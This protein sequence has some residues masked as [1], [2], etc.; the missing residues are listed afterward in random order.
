MFL[1]ESL[2]TLNDEI[3]K[4]C[5]YDSSVFILLQFFTCFKSVVTKFISSFLFPIYFISREA[6]WTKESGNCHQKVIKNT[7]GVRVGVELYS[8]LFWNVDPSCY[9]QGLLLM[10]L[11]AITNTYF[12]DLHL[13]LCTVWVGSCFAKCIS[14]LSQ[15][16][17]CLFLN[18][19]A[20]TVTFKRSLFKRLWFWA[21]LCNKLLWWM[22]DPVFVVMGW[23]LFLCFLR[24]VVC[25]YLWWDAAD[26]GTL[27]LLVPCS[28]NGCSACAL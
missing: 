4:Q 2:P 28:Q 19:T 18:S 26:A 8:P 22:T 12:G 16:P 3:L 21:V 24:E 20:G 9:K 11:T 7:S 10:I 23:R 14:L 27:A 17:M 5:F 1:L 6:L 25:A 13:H 15:T